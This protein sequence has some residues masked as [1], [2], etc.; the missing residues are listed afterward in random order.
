MT[1]SKKNHIHLFVFSLLL[2]GIFS[3]DLNA[4]NVSQ[5]HCMGNGKYCVFGQGSD[6]ESVFGPS[7]S[8]PSYIELKLNQHTTTSSVRIQG[9]AIWQHTLFQN[10][11]KIAVITDF[12]DNLLPI[13]VRKIDCYQEFS[14]ELNILKDQKITIIDDFHVK[15]KNNSSILIYK[16]RGLPIYGNY[17]HP[18]EQFQHIY[19]KGSSGISKVEDS[20]Y[21]LKINPGKSEFYIIG[22]PSFRECV[23]N[24]NNV[25]SVNFSILYERTKKYWDDFTKRRYDFEKLIPNSLPEKKQILSQIDNVAIILKTQQAEEGAVIA[26][27]RYHLAYVRDQYGVSRGFLSMGYYEEA[28]QI[29]NFYWNIWKMF[30]Y[31]HNAQA[32]GV[33]GIFHEHENDEV[34]ITGYLIIQAFDYLEKTG[35]TT[36]IKKI[37]PML[38]WAWNAQKKNLYKGMLPFNGDETYVAGGILPRTALNDGSSEATLLFLEGG[39]RMLPFIEKNKLWKQQIIEKD[40]TLIEKTKASFLKDF[41]NGRQIIANNPARMDIA[42]M[43][44]FRHGMCAGLHGVIETQKDENGNYLCPKCIKEGLTPPLIERKIYY[45][46]SLALTPVYIGSKIIPEDILDHNLS[47]IKENYLKK[48]QISSREDQNLVIGYEYGFF[49]YSLARKKDPVAGK[50]LK[51]M[52]SVVDEV[53]AWVEYYNDGN[54]MGCNYRPWESA[55][56]IESIILYANNY[57]R[58]D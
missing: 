31:I 16:D 8:S 17:T 26:G 40:K 47:F 21:K 35:D 20:H 37:F 15:Q 51:D 27:H 25:D 22:G 11:K 42:E 33:S 54:P 10:E 58:K 48:R 49:L 53:G 13:F 9:T 18:Y 19:T 32:I 3:Y 46:P 43:P 56:N 39:N 4:A 7:Y 44:E 29:L 28:K 2:A 12:V 30:G 34:E 50:V 1:I 5:L 45:L 52:P 6:I 24:T 55:I 38:E 23:E 41:I 36:F 57:E 14:F